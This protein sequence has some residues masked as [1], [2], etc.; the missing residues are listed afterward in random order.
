[1]SITAGVEY[2]DS[3]AFDDRDLV[4]LFFVGL[5]DVFFSVDGLLNARVDCG[6]LSGGVAR[7][8]LLGWGSMSPG[9]PNG[10]LCIRKVFIIEW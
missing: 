9:G 4:V 7:G 2:F 1:M 3:L 6:S 5:V 8:L 10:N